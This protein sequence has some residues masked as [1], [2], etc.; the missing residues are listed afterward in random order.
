MLAAVIPQSKLQHLDISANGIT[1]W[2]AQ[3]LWASLGR[4]A[5]YLVCL[6]ME[7]NPVSIRLFFEA[8]IISA[9][10]I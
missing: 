4:D 5:S 10:T 9:I 3:Q 6:R 7:A 8:I 1:D 2:G